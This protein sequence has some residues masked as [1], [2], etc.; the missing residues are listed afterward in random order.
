MVRI[1][2]DLHC[3]D[4]ASVG[5][6]FTID[7]RDMIPEEKFAYFAVLA[8]RVAISPL[9]AINSVF[10]SSIARTREPPASASRHSLVEEDGKHL[11]RRF[12]RSQAKTANLA[13][14]APV[15]G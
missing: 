10:N 1:F 5:C 14:A 3:L 9:L 6:P 2:R 15:H 4:H 13:G 7:L 12:N 8:I 11:V